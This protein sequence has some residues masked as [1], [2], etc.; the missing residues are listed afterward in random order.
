VQLVDQVPEG[1]DFDTF[2]MRLWQAVQRRDAAY[3]ETFLP[4]EGIYIGLDDP[5]P[6]HLLALENTDAPFWRS[7]EKMLAPQS[8]ELVDYPGTSPDAA[9]WGCPNVD[10][11]LYASLAVRS[12]GSAI[13]G[14]LPVLVLGQRVNVR[15]HPS[16]NTAIVGNV[17]NAMLEFDYD[18]WLE[19]Q[20]TSPE[21]TDDPLDGWTPVILPNQVQGYV[22]NRYV[23]HPQGPKALFEL[24]DGHWRLM[25][26]LLSAETAPS[27]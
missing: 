13:G 3:L 21:T 1:S 4:E 25:R 6:S 2:R 12:N 7:L 17:S 22:Y 26:I 18:T 14:S 15:S 9:V 24:V 23:Y 10:S 11:A 16:R 19:L 27:P 20:Q 5:I 8:C